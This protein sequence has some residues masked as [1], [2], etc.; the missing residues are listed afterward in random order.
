MT[1]KPVVL[2]IGGGAGGILTAAHL[3][4]NYCRIEIL[5]VNSESHFGTGVAYQTHSNAHLLNV[6]TGKMSAFSDDP[7]DFVRWI[8][9]QDL[10]PGIQEDVLASTYLPRKIFGD[11]LKEVWERTKNSRFN[12]SSV[13]ELLGRVVDVVQGTDSRFVVHFQDKRKIKADF[14]VLA[15]GNAS[16]RNPIIPNA[17][18]LNSKNYF[19]NPW[20]VSCTKNLDHCKDI[21]IVGNGL[22]MVDV[23]QSLVDEKFSGTIHS[24]SPNGFGIQPHQHNGITYNGLLEEL[25]NDLRLSE[26]VSLLNKHIKKVKLLGLSA[27]LVI[28]SLRSR[29]QSIWMSLSLEEKQ[30]FLMRLRHLW[31]VARHRLPIRVYDFV[32]QL[33][34]D[35]R[36][37]IWSGWLHDVDDKQGEITVD[38]R[39]RNSRKTKSLTVS[40]VI[41]CTGPE[42]DI[43]RMNDPLFK[44][45]ISSGMITP[46]PVKLGLEADP[47]SLLI[48]DKDENVVNSFYAI[49]GL[50]R[51]LLWESTAI[52]EIREQAKIIADH[53]SKSSIIQ[54]EVNALSPPKPHYES[55]KF[56]PS[57]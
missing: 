54:P 29:T 48:K 37:K 28:D 22:T 43:E 38:F 53:I 44:N 23:V 34:L 31:G 45:L 36:L 25:K 5:V 46:H 26:L 27:E 41:N 14:V 39:E 50:L 35:G 1:D 57:L 18:F 30:Q 40:R 24:L 42:T 4:R 17:G 32:Q 2:I 52:P 19:N 56:R 55:E 8:S 9:D 11:Y 51:G 49:G 12:S 21:L 15:T 10:F 7:D 47:L 16:P 6:M 20:S 13:T 33:K 3:I